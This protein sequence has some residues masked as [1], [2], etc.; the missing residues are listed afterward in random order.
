MSKSALIEVER[1]SNVLIYMMPK[2]L[3]DKLD[4]HIWEFECSCR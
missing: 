3:R 4:V 2:Y 1:N